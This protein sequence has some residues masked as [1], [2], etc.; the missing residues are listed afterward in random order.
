MYLF[1]ILQSP[2]VVKRGSNIAGLLAAIFRDECLATRVA[3]DDLGVLQSAF[4]K[5]LFFNI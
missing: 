4:F 2:K 1:F 5:F 3:I